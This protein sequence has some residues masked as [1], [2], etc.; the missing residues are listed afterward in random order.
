MAD[1]KKWAK[2]EDAVKEVGAEKAL[3]YLNHGFNDIAYRTNRRKQ[4]QELLKRIKK[5]PKYM[6]Q[7]AKKG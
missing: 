5:D 4:E 2:W 6:D 7:L 3:G 1:K